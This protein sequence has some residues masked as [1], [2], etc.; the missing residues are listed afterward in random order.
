MNERALYGKGRA[1]RKFCEISAAFVATPMHDTH[2]PESL[3]TPHAYHRSS[4][5]ALDAALQSA[6]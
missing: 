4:G 1:W 2:D 5:R 3:A 6:I